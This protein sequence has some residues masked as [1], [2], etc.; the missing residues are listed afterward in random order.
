VW[1]Q[2]EGGGTRRGGTGRVEVEGL[3]KEGTE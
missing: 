3:E 1:V 2:R